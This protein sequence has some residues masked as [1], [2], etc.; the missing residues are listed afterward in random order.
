MSLFSTVLGAVA[1]P[2]VSG[3]FGKSSAD[4]SLDAQRY[5]SAHAHQI[6]VADLKAA[7][8]NPILSAKYGGAGGVGGA[9]ATMPGFDLNSAMATAKQVKLL[10]QQEKTS[11]A[12]EMLKDAQRHWYYE[13]KKKVEEEIK[14]VQANTA[15][16]VK[17]NKIMDQ[18][19]A[20]SKIEAE[21]DK[22][23]YG[24]IMRYL[25]RLNPFGNSAKG[26]WTVPGSK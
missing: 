12:D 22:S 11:D 8:L 21:I 2:V 23:N 16:V 9:T 5:Q 10:D 25:N 7:G 15:N 18:G 13:Q 1:G 17:Q 19:V 14:N 26:I 4:K 6:E 20:A 3:L 24:R